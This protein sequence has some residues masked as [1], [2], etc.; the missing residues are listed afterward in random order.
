MQRIGL[1]CMYSQRRNSGK[2]ARQIQRIGAA[3]PVLLIFWVWGHW[4]A[5][6][7][8]SCTLKA[9]IVKS[10][11]K[12]ARTPIVKFHVETQLMSSHCIS[13]VHAR[14]AS[15]HK[16]HRG[17]VHILGPSAPVPFHPRTLCRGWGP[18]LSQLEQGGLVAQRQA[19]HLN[20]VTWFTARRR[21]QTR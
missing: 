4:A 12:K 9:N 2:R 19:L 18:R 3:G 5:R 6:V 16:C 20:N 11:R 21:T 7:W 1:G 17:S 10:L 14:I 8:E 13:R 15:V